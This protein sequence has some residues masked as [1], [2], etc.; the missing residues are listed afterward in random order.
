MCVV[1]A[2]LSFLYLACCYDRVYLIPVGRGQDSGAVLGM[3]ESVYACVVCTVVICAPPCA[4]MLSE[5]DGVGGWKGWRREKRK[6][7]V[8]EKRD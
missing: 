6:K 1:C 4:V 8:F 5:C 2:V 7:Q 3:G